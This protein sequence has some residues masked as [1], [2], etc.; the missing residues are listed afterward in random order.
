MASLEPDSYL[1][2]QDE[3]L[4]RSPSYMDAVGVVNRGQ[5]GIQHDTLTHRLPNG[6]SESRPAM[7]DDG[8]R[9]LQRTVSMASINKNSQPPTPAPGTKSRD[10]NPN[11]PNY[12]H[13]LDQDL[14][15]PR[16]LYNYLTFSYLNMFMRLGSQRQLAPEDLYPVPSLDEAYYLTENLEA[17]WKEQLDKPKGS[18]FKAFVGSFYKRWSMASLMLSIEAIFQVFEP[19]LLGR[20]ISSTADGASDR[21]VY[22]YTGALIAAVL[23]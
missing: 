20:I 4:V 13:P 9:K 5:I 23:V 11:Y 2:A 18:L 15:S 3:L 12:F 21:V 16:R 14:W 17:A 10:S 6:T 22:G 19:F 8:S 7:D 1:D